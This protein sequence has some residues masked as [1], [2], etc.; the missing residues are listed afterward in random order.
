MPL[1]FAAA[2]LLG[3]LSFFLPRRLDEPIAEAAVFTALVVVPV[4]FL[5]YLLLFT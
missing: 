3:V 1:P 4:G 5:L 2:M